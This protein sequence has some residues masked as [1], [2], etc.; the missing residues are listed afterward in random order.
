MENEN[1]QV[2]DSA[3]E[4]IVQSMQSDIAS[5]VYDDPEVALQRIEKA[6]EL[7]P[8]WEAAVQKI[9]VN[10]TFPS[11]WEEFGDGDKAK[12]CLSS[13]G[14]ERI[15]KH[16]PIQIHSVAFEKEEFTDSVGKGYRY[17]YSGYARLRERETYVQGNY[18]TRDKFLGFAGGEYR[19]I[20]DMNEGM[21][22]NAAYH[23]FIGNGIKAILGIRALPV[24]K[25]NELM[26][27]LG[28]KASNAGGHSYNR[29]NQGGS[30]KTKE[31]GKANTDLRNLILEIAEAGYKFSYEGEGKYDLE[32][33]LGDFNVEAVAKESCTNLTAFYVKKDKK[34]VP[35]VDNVTKMAAKRAGVAL[36]NARKIWK[37]FQDQNAN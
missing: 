31:Q 21:I 8:R 37:E 29:G 18:S 24:D 16:F 30:T 34:E 5:L 20:V 32:A 2:V 19:D 36:G 27:E 9:L 10:A 35:G 17:T 25:F 15:A 28:K 33:V 13:A 12:M 1:P 14:A 3:N 22:R 4:T 26:S 11:D 23:I 7:A 6:A